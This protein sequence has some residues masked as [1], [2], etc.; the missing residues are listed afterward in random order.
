[1]IPVIGI[2]GKMGTGK[3]TTAEILRNRCL[4]VILSF[5]DALKAEAAMRYNFNRD[6]TYSQE[7]KNTCI[8]HPD[9]PTGVL[10][11]R[12]ILQYY[13][14]SKRQEDPLYWDRKVENQMS[15]MIRLGASM[16]IIDDVRHPSECEMIRTVFGGFLFRLEPYPSWTAGP[17]ARHHSEI[18]LDEYQ[19][20]DEVYQPAFGDLDTVATSILLHLQKRRM[21]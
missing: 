9:L 16:V 18:A 4:G 13:G 7:G 8:C 19:E 17:H 3:T 6:L 21:I 1:M 11:V 15:E 14:H 20:W 12:E 5:A 2:A 10:S